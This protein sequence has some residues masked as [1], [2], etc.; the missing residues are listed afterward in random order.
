MTDQSVILCS[1]PPDP[2][3]MKHEL[4]TLA[5]L[6]LVLAGCQRPAPKVA[7]PEAV[8]V[9]VAV[10]SQ[11]LVTQFEEFTG[12]TS[13]VKTVEV[14]PRVTGFVQEAVSYTHLRAHETPE[15]LVCRL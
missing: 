4:L 1:P 11:E 8:K 5:L 6:Y 3:T 10:P 9:K 12:R 13:A 2:P 14:K 15:H 7:A